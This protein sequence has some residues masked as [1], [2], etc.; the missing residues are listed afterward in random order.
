VLFWP[1]SACV[2]Q[3]CVDSGRVAMYLGVFHLGDLLMNSLF[4]LE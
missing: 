1:V 2:C 4:F 3:P